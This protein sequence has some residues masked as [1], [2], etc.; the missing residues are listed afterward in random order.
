MNNAEILK[1]IKELERDVRLLKIIVYKA[2]T[3]AA[4]KAYKQLYGVE[5]TILKSV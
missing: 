4:E 1:R 2:G 3:I 5:D